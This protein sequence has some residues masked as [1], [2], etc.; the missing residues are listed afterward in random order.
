MKKL[1]LFFLVLVLSTTCSADTC[2]EFRYEESV[3]SCQFFEDVDLSERTERIADLLVCDDWMNANVCKDAPSNRCGFTWEYSRIYGGLDLVTCLVNHSSTYLECDSSKVSRNQ[4]PKDRR[5]DV[6]SVQMPSCSGGDEYYLLKRRFAIDPTGEGFESSLVLDKTD[7]MEKSAVEF[8]MPSDKKII[9]FSPRGEKPEIEIKGDETH[10]IW[11]KKDVEP[12]IPESYM[13]PEYIAHD[14]LLVS[15]E[16][17]FTQIR[18]W[19]SESYTPPEQRNQKIKEL[20]ASI[21][22]NENG[23]RSIQLLYDWV[24]KNIQYE[25][26]KF[27]MSVGF[28]PEQPEKTVEQR[29]GD[30]KDMSVL[31][32]E[33]LKAQGFS[34]EPALCC[35]YHNMPFRSS[36]DHVLVK[37]E[38]NNK[39]IW[40]DPTCPVCPYRVLTPNMY[41]KYVFPLSGADV[42]KLPIKDKPDYITNAII[43]FDLSKIE[44]ARITYDWQ[45]GDLISAEE[46]RV[47]IQSMSPQE[48]AGYYQQ[49][50]R[51]ICPYPQVIEKGIVNLNDSLKPLTVHVVYDCPGIVGVE[52]DVLRFMVGSS[53]QLPPYLAK[54]TRQNDIYLAG[55]EY[56]RITTRVIFPEGYE[57]STKPIAYNYSEGNFSFTQTAEIVGNQLTIDSIS[58]LNQLIPKEEYPA[59][60]KAYQAQ[61]NTRQEIVAKKTSGS[62]IAIAF[63]AVILL[64]FAALIL[65]K[66][67]K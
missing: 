27:D 19:L 31:L 4:S 37:V 47:K 10:Y 48:L 45:Y 36:F 29:K 51:K 16:R 14:T 66:K 64:V 55:S 54:N 17:N 15:S 62:T 50:A 34:A 8:V 26:G 2:N 53:G 43:T 33:L 57:I 58:S 32:S 5:I 65:R 11:Q 28:K 35:S 24:R 38:Y 61:L 52:K 56:T 30:C 23:E 40:L 60:R 20:S 42:E 21:V 25:V 1:T 67:R 3:Y 6:L 46:Q 39:T 41:E 63:L 13:P 59:L 7:F 18:D 9:Y 22:G 49:Q 12:V 44:T